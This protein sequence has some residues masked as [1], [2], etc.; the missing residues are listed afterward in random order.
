MMLLSAVRVAAHRNARDQR[1][2]GAGDVQH[3]DFAVAQRRDVERVFAGDRD[4]KGTL[5]AGHTLAGG[6]RGVERPQI[7]FVFHRVCGGVNHTDRVIVDIGDGEQ[8]AAGG[9]GQAG[10]GRG[11]QEADAAR[12]EAAGCGVR[13]V[14]ERDRGAERPG[15]A[16]VRVGINLVVDVAGHVEGGA[17]GGEDEAFERVGDLDD[18]LQCGRGSVGAG[19]VVD[20]DIFVRARR[21]EIDEQRGAIGA[22]RGLD[23]LAGAVTGMV[24]EARIQILKNGARSGRRRDVLAGRHEGLRLGRRSEAAGEYG[25]GREN[26]AQR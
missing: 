5:A 21:L 13:L 22:Q 19:D 8:R 10:G 9:K 15:A 18:L 7:V 26:T 24:G 17:G 16:A 3:D 1:G 4:G 2:R 12:G 14:A 23:R 25:G 20:E 6:G 11:L